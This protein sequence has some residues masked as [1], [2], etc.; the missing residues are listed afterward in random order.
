MKKTFLLSIIL[1]VATFSFSQNVGIN[2]TGALPDS[3]AML[4]VSSTTKGFLPPRM[5]LAQRNLISLPATGII[6]YQTDDVNG[7]YVNKGTAAVPDWQ[8]IGPASP[9]SYGYFST[10]ATADTVGRVVPRVK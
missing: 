6:V 2:A 7:L 4:D 10:A 1:F 5:T 3:S 8:L 9:L